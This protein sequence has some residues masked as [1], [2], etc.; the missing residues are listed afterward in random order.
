[1]YFVSVLGW[2]TTLLLAPRLASSGFNFHHTFSVKTCFILVFFYEDCL[3]DNVCSLFLLILV[4]FPAVI[5]M[6]SY[7][8]AFAVLWECRCH[9]NPFLPDGNT[10]LSFSS[11]S[12]SS[13]SSSSP[14]AWILIDIRC[15]EVLVPVIIITKE[16][17]IILLSSHWFI[18]RHSHNVSAMICDKIPSLKLQSPEQ[19][20]ELWINGIVLCVEW[21]SQ[22]CQSQGQDE[23]EQGGNAKG[24]VKPWKFVANWFQRARTTLAL[25]EKFFPQWFKRVF[26]GKVDGVVHIYALESA[27]WKV[28]SSWQSWSPKVQSQIN[29]QNGE[30]CLELMTSLK[31]EVCGGILRPE[32]KW[33]P[34]R[35]ACLGF[36]VHTCE[37]SSNISKR[38]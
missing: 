29:K 27:E 2:Q 4:Q 8:A 37:S 5:L 25:T 24:Q 11:L 19:C 14:P 18:T 38:K 16:I 35:Q 17:V 28:I 3:T 30:F 31:L 22:R 34:R 9:N 33:N 21:R 10:M 36:R 6:L 32:W 26:R 20:R 13:L 15:I 12:S 1:M 23:R 7:I